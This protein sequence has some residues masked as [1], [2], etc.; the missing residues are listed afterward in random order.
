MTISIYLSLGP[1]PKKQCSRGKP[2][3]CGQTIR[4]EH[5]T[6]SRNLHSH[7]FGSPLSNAQEV[8]AFGDEGENLEQRKSS[9]ISCTV[10]AR[11]MCTPCIFWIFQL[12]TETKITKLHLGLHLTLMDKTISREIS[13][14]SRWPPEKPSSLANQKSILPNIT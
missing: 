12:S 14:A 10:C 6:T 4:F 5:I 13:L 7:H 11:L 1:T 9:L 3:E 2:I 8:S